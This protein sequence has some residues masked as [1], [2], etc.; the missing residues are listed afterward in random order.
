[1][2]DF[3]AK[4][5]HALAGRT[6]IDRFFKCW[7][8]VLP[9]TSVLVFPSIQGTTPAYIMA[10]LTVPLM[11]YAARTK[12]IKQYLTIAFLIAVGY[13]T[14]NVCSQF[15]LSLYGDMDL[16]SL[17]LVDPLSFT[18]K[19][20]LRPTLFTQT[21]Y[22]TAC[23]LTFLFVY[24][25]YRPSWDPYIFAGILMLV[26]YGFYEVFYYWATGTSGDFLS[27]RF[28][29]ERYFGSSTQVFK[30]G[31]ISLLRMKSLTGEASM[32][33][34][35]VLP[36]W[37]YAIHKQRY[38][39]AGILTLALFFSTSTTAILGIVT[40]IVILILGRKIDWKYLATSAAVLLAVVIIKFETVYSVF[41]ELVL[42]KLTGASISGSVRLSNMLDSL[43]F[44]WEAPFPLKI[45]GLGFGYIRSTDFFSTILV[46]NGII[47]LA[48]FLLVFTFPIL[49]LGKTSKEFA[50]KAAL[51]III[52]TM[53][54][55]VTEYTYLPTWLFLGISYHYL[56][57][58]DA[59]SRRLF[60]LIK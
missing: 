23:L 30:M 35:T 49:A 52:V 51:S 39:I 27:N 44:W 19:F 10:F 6:F 47:G 41:N 54:I 11:L 31:G 60:R 20:V 33:A 58:E 46:N 43:A 2:N 7:A 21:L 22:L 38:I 4:Y 14:L 18:Q 25:W 56:T 53:M 17:P 48:I 9:V 59:I 57:E 26:A 42:K 5:R 40:Y 16:S 8:L 1:M 3:V 15:F 28:F 12:E 13:I 50:L 36:Y 37:V 29:N 24:K 45:F 32:F 34:F 55:A